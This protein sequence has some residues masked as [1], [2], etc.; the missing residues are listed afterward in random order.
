MECK[1]TWVYAPYVLTSNP[2]QYPKICSKCGTTDIE[3]AIV[4]I[5]ETESYDDIVERFN[6]EKK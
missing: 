3:P 4:P 2:P 5:R 6:K 1:H